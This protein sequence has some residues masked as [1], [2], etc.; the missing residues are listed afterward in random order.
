MSRQF[1]VATW[2]YRA[3]LL[4][5]ALL[6]LF[7]V[8]RN[9]LGNIL[10]EIGPDRAIV[11]DPGHAH[12]L[13]SAAHAKLLVARDAKDA[14]G[15]V[16]ISRAAL[17][18]SPLAVV[19]L[20]NVGLMAEAR[21]DEEQADRVLTLAGRIS[22]RDSLV[23]AWLFDRRNRQGR[24]NEAILAAD[25]ALRE[26]VTVWDVLMGELIKLVEQPRARE[27]IA[28][29]LAGRPYWGGTFVEKLGSSTAA[30]ESVYALLM[31]VKALGAPPATNELRSYFA[32]FDGT[33]APQQL[34]SQWL[35]LKPAPGVPPLLRDGSFSGYDA[36][37]PFVWSLFP[38]DSVVSEISPAPHGDGR[39]LYLAYNG[40]DLANFAHQTLA[41]SPGRYQLS[42]KSIGDDAIQPGQ[43]ILSV[44]CGGTNATREIAKL[45]LRP[46]TED[47]QVLRLEF[48]VPADCPAQQI[49]ISGQKILPRHPA[50]LWI[51]DVKIKRLPA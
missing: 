7:A 18:T 25:T 40:A 45:A 10:A 46:P 31:R 22:K 41:L 38:N 13:E 14:E 32:R 12:A 50:S 26:N 33:T 16:R 8:G 35:A 15:V 23:Q 20:R 3:A 11:I 44:R 28:V 42:L 29:V 34:W 37:P 27:R 21:G 6:T 39:S 5:I 51:D 4:G 24:I 17:R 19:A 9:G 36:P 1:R 2:G 49:W 47:W 48:A 30:S 43:F